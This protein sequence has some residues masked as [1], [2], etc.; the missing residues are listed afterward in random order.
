MPCHLA[1]DAYL[2][3]TLSDRNLAPTGMVGWGGKRQIHYVHDNGKRHH[4]LSLPSVPVIILWCPSGFFFPKSSSRDPHEPIL[5]ARKLLPT[6]FFRAAP[7]VLALG[8]GQAHLH[9]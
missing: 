6:P 5:Q 4:L 1:P 8:Q 7:H 3:R 2:G 9:T